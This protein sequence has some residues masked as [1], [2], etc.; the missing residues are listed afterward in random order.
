MQR[1][2]LGE[3]QQAV[4]MR[5]EGG[6]DRWGDKPSISCPRSVP[7]LSYLW[8]YCA[9]QTPVSG[10]QRSKGV[11]AFVAQITCPHFGVSRPVDLTRVRAKDNLKLLM[12]VNKL[13]WELFGVVEKK[14][15]KLSLSSVFD[16]SVYIQAYPLL[17]YL[18]FDQIIMCICNPITFLLLQK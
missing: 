5:S 14:V 15:K 8:D 11:T 18:E 12:L 4:Y 6:D 13:A 2:R 10:K 1:A 7:Y 9:Y 16:C 3:G 17:L